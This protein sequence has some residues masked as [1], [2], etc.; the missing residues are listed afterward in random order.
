M[1]DPEVLR[2][3]ID[4]GIRDCIAD[5]VPS[6]GSDRSL[7]QIDRLKITIFDDL[8]GLMKGVIEAAQDDLLRDP[9]AMQEIFGQLDRSEKFQLS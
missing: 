7:L 6:Q 3:A 8:H 4:V 2:K 9:H 5:L 1:A